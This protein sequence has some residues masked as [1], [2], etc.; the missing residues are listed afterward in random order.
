MWNVNAASLTTTD[1]GMEGRRSFREASANDRA[2]RIPSLREPD[3][4]GPQRVR[5][6]T[7]LI[8]F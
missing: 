3:Q 1:L 6:G 7:S 4:E 5:K 2:L 8:E